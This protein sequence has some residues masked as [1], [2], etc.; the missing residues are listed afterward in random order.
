MRIQ[1]SKKYDYALRTMIHLA[2]LPI[3]SRTTIQAV[4]D[5]EGIPRKFLEKIIRDLGAAGIVRTALG[6]HGG[7][8]LGRP[9]DEIRFADI[10]RVTD[11]PMQVADCTGDH[12]ECNHADSCAMAHVWQEIQAGADRVLHNT[13]LAQVVARGVPVAPTAP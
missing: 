9:A 12:A 11:G 8:S 7:L 13:T 1:L 6:K 5:S 2:R 4:A 3:G 10:M